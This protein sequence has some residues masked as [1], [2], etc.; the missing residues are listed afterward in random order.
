MRA[1]LGLARTKNMKLKHDR[2]SAYADRRGSRPGR[3]RACKAVTTWTYRPIRWLLLR[4]RRYALRL[5]LYAN[6][7][8]DRVCRGDQGSQD[9]L[10]GDDRCGLCSEERRRGLTGIGQI[11]RRQPTSSIFNHPSVSRIRQLQRQGRSRTYGNSI[12]Y[13]GIIRCRPPVRWVLV[14]ESPAR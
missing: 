8:G 13:A 7:V 6:R 2:R 5:V 1:R 10:K 4:E 12:T 14:N 3:A 9:R 11:R